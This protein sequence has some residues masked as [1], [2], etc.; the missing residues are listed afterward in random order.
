MSDVIVNY[1][2]MKWRDAGDAYPR[3]TKIKVLRDEEGGKTVLLKLTK[4]FKMGAHCHI[5]NEQHFVLKGQYEMEGKVYAQGTYQLIHSN[6]THG[7]FTSKTG[8]V[9][10][11]VWN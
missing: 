11:V 9:I 4:G 6:M 10:L 5:G 2:S 3:G 1:N 8:A 7:S